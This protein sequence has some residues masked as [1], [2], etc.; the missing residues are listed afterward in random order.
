MSSICARVAT[1]EAGQ[2][3]I[4]QIAGNGKFAAIQCGIA[5]TMDAAAGLNLQRD[6]I[7]AGTS[8]DHAGIDN[9]LRTDVHG[10]DSCCECGS[11]V[12]HSVLEIGHTTLD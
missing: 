12:L 1:D 3:V 6:E 4:G 11:I 7:A 5:E 2:H 10:L 8:D 9:R